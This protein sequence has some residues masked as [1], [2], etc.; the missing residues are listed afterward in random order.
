MVVG[1]PSDEL[2]EALGVTKDELIMPYYNNMIN[3][4]Y[5]PGWKGVV[6]RDAH[7]QGS[8]IHKNLSN[9]KGKLNVWIN[10]RLVQISAYDSDNIYSMPSADVAKAGEHD[11][12]EK[13][14]GGTSKS[15]MDG[16]IGAH[17][18]GAVGAQLRAKHSKEPRIKL[19]DYPGLR[20]RSEQF[21]PTDES[22]TSRADSGLGSSNGG[23]EISFNES[24]HKNLPKAGKI[25]GA[26]ARAEDAAMDVS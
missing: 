15:V 11:G 12:P 5:P 21:K 18:Q 1:N 24:K 25:V 14:R 7:K 16:K 17:Y 2:K 3:H 13:F 22:Q 6:R 26:T 8:S 19:V 23:S 10:G 9:A 4:C 20:W